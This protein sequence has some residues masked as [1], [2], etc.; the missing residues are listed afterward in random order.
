MKPI[1]TWNESLIVLLLI[2]A[3]WLM[4]WGFWLAGLAIVEWL[5]HYY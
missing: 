3:S 2:I 4:L 1:Y 5:T